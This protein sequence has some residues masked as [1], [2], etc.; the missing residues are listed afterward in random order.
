MH[1]DAQRMPQ[2][3]V[4]DSTDGFLHVKGL[5]GGPKDVFLEL[6]EIPCVKALGLRTAFACKS[7]VL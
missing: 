3:F 1:K 5:E 4:A 7:V 6:R 2:D